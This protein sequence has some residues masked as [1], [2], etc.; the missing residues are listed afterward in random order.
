M[1]ILKNGAPVGGPPGCLGR[2]RLAGL[3][4]AVLGRLLIDSKPTR[5]FLKKNTLQNHDSDRVPLGLGRFYQYVRTVGLMLAR[6]INIYPAAGRRA[7]GAWR[8]LNLVHVRARTNP[9][10]DRKT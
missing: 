3:L 7:R 10:P 9:V 4:D 6:Y 2:Y 8:V 1:A 5:V